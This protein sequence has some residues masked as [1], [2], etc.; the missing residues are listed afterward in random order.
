MNWRKWHALLAVLCV[1]TLAL[2]TFSGCGTGQ[3]SLKVVKLDSGKISGVKQGGTWTYLGIPYAKP[4]VGNLRWKPPEA[5]VAWSGTRACTKYGATCPQPP[6]LVSFGKTS[7]DCLYLN[8]WT[9]AKTSTEKL[10]V[11]VWIYGGAFTTGSGSDPRFN[12]VNLSKQDV[13]VVTINYRVGMF[14]LIAHPELSKESPHH[15]SGNYGLMDMIQALKW[16]KKNIN[17]FGGDPGRVTVFGQSSGAESI[18]Y[19]LVSPPAKGLFQRAISESGPRWHYGWISPMN[20]SLKDA[21]KTGE[22]MA[23]NLG[24]GN[25]SD[26]IAAMRAKSSDEVL[27]AAGYNVLASDPPTGIQAAVNVDGWIIPEKPETLYKA[28]KQMNVPVLIGSNRDDGTLFGGIVQKNNIPA[29]QYQP[30]I[31][32]AVGEPAASE[33]VS[34]FPV[35]TNAQVGA[36]VSNLLTQM[37]FASCARYICDSTIAKTTSKAFLYQFTRVPPTQAGTLLGCCHSAELE[38]VFGNLPASQGYGPKDTEISN[39]MMGY[40]TR[41]AKTGDPKGGGSPVWPSYSSKD[42]NMEIGDQVT[43]NS[44]LFKAQCDLSEKIYA[45]GKP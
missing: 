44:G 42:Q 23:V 2:G 33:V 11:M 7:E 5:P 17:G 20:P 13:I 15:S 43:V 30:I 40:W 37:D 34:M 21:E 32:G 19:L 18:Q 41:F 39:T 29:S 1:M 14:G 35:T 12:G 24:C 45:G 4:P 16:V 3:T 26:Q 27:K 31:Q 25:A 8:V 28:G 9:P 6:G 36:T 10:P 38:Y 22:Q